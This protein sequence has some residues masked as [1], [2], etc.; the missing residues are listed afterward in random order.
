M[1]A[2]ACGELSPFLTQYRGGRFNGQRVEGSEVTGEVAGLVW[3]TR[4]AR[5]A[6]AYASPGVDA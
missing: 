4:N 6:T 2:P 1:S 3:R 5:K